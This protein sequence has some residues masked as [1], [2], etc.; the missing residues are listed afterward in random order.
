M[1]KL[2]NKF[3]ISFILKLSIKF[4]LIVMV[5]KR[6]QAAKKPEWHTTRPSSVNSSST[7][8]TACDWTR[9]NANVLPLL[10]LRL[11][12]ANQPIIDSSAGRSVCVCVSV[13]GSVCVCVPEIISRHIYPHW[14]KHEVKT[15]TEWLLIFD[16]IHNI[17]TS[18]FAL[19]KVF[20]QSIAVQ[21]SPPSSSV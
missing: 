18:D 20:T 21:N 1:V 11:V 16:W 7:Q 14:Q 13:T 19:M 3:T 17:D 5:E 2:S 10:W 8:R 15:K 9:L 4:K 12:Q 6:H